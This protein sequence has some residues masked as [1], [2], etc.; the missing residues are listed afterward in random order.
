MAGNNTYLLGSPV[1]DSVSVT[2]EHPQNVGPMLRISD[3]GIV[4]ATKRTSN[5]T[6]VQIT[7]K[8]QSPSNVYVQSATM[9]GKELNTPFITLEELIG[10]SSTTIEV[11][12]GDVP[13]SWGT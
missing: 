1:F 11:T 2:I 4:T 8:N 7:A 3:E 5:S 6:V 12:L 10:S 9:N 13:S